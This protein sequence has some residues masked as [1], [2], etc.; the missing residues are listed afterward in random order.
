[1][2][3]RFRSKSTS[4]RST[5][6]S[7]FSPS[8]VAVGSGTI[9]GVEKD[10]STRALAGLTLLQGL[11]NASGVDKLINPLKAGLN[12]KLIFDVSTTMPTTV[13]LP[14]TSAEPKKP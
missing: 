7:S 3:R 2:N 11:G 14:L 4:C 12:A 1:M 10:P 8:I 6:D 9:I 13:W 5:S